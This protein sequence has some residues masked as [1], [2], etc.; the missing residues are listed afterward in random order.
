M[1]DRREILDIAGTLGLL[2]QVV[3]KD[4]VLGWVLAGIYRQAALAESWI[5]KGGTCL[6]K[7]YFETYRFSEDLDFTLIDPSHI[8]HVFLAGVFR[9][10]G[11][12]IYEQTG[13]K[14]P[15][16]LQEFEIFENPRGTMSCQ[17]K[18]SYRGPIA[19]RSGGLP[20]IK[21]DLTPD[22]ILVLPPA[23]RV[24]YHDYSDAPEGGILVRCYAYEEAFAEKT[25]ALGERTRP[26]DL[27][28]VINLYRN[29]DARPQSAV[30]KDVLQQK[31]AHHK[32]P[33]PTLA[34]LETY[35]GDLEGSWQSMLRHQL[36]ALPP[37]ESYWE[38]L[39]E[40]FN[41]LETGLAPA[42]PATYRMTNGETV[43][44][45]RTLRLPVSA[46]VQ[47]YLEI[48]RFAAA[49]HLCVD[50]Q[51][52]GSVR[53]IEPYS[54]RRTR[55]GNIIL[56]ATRASDD[57]HRSYRIDRIEGARTT[58]QSY[59]P[60]F[61]V[62]LSPK[63]PAVISP[64]PARS[65]SLG[66]LRRQRPASPRRLGRTA[67]SSGLRYI[68][69][70]GYCGKRFTRKKMASGLN[71]HKDKSGYPCPGRTAILVDTQY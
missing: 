4:Y 31:C 50:L 20:R 66:G 30:L 70:C 13:I 25:R 58:R 48:I 52:Q 67:W 43:L 62:E 15:E 22:E 7:C 32:L 24:I 8:D 57:Q 63:G 51:Y 40:F 14:L 42:V 45:E 39:S 28:D 27:Y 60:R 53:R 49:N 10:I 26:R 9:N 17:G 21:L 12:W 3:E 47:S 61:E 69:E 65:E 37:V 71:P 23:E 41:W 33:V 44:R 46:K 55:D 38:M 56:H 5:F 2:P 34:E 36:Q 1:I 59:V 35:R 64:T 6:K 16:N 68:Y 29:T 11:A 18:L 19:P 54:L